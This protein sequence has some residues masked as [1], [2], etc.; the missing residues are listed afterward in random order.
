MLHDLSYH[1]Y[2]VIRCISWPLHLQRLRKWRERT[3][4]LRI[5]YFFLVDSPKYLLAPSHLWMMRSG[6]ILEKGPVKC[7]SFMCLAGCVHHQVTTTQHAT[8]PHPAHEKRREG[9]GQSTVPPH[10]ETPHVWPWELGECLQ[11]W[12][13]RAWLRNPRGLFRIP[14][15][16]SGLGSS[17]VVSLAGG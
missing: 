12:W 16:P 14:C 8:G 5:K 4:L 6:E 10:V 9:T 11:P 13:Q 7:I 3:I 17:R 15:I 2:L 1:T